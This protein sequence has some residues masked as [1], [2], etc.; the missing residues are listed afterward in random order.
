[1]LHLRQS[2]RRRYSDEGAFT[3]VELLVVIAIIGILVALLL[4]AVQAARE[5]ARRM[6]CANNL[7]QIALAVQ[8]YE[9][10]YKQVPAGSVYDESP[11]WLVFILPFMEQQQLYDL[12]NLE[13]KWHTPGFNR[14]VLV[15]FKSGTGQVAAY[16]CPSRQR[17]A[18]EFHPRDTGYGEPFQ[19]APFGDYAGNKGTHDFCCDFSKAHPRP[20]SGPTWPA[21]GWGFSH[22]G[23]IYNQIWGNDCCMP[24]KS[25]MSYRKKI[26]SRSTQNDKAG[27]LHHMTSRQLAKQLPR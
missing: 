19:D 23:V 3:L 22:D 26:N 14:D 1:M 8:N 12:W 13:S 21:N 4:P 7:K 27:A 17:E 5:S 16:R 6:Q 18:G 24:H 15:A 25:N 11:T 10:T 2:D 20:M 9:S